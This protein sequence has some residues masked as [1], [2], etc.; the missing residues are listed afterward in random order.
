MAYL[1]LSWQPLQFALA[2]VIVISLHRHLA[3]SS[4]TATR[5]AALAKFCRQWCGGH[6][7]SGGGFEAAAPLS[8]A[9]GPTRPR[10]IE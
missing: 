7:H 3:K 8:A 10:Q 6:E 4:C 9:N 5:S 1:Y 2:K